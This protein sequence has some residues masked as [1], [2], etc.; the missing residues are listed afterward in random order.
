MSV[1]VELDKTRIC[2]SEAVDWSFKKWL[3][4]QLLGDWH[5]KMV[6]EM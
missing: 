3:W 2:I 6:R 1:K 4:G 5:K